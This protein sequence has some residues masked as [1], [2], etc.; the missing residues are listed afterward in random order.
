M[1]GKKK[2]SKKSIIGIIVSSVIGIAG[3]V[4]AIVT[5]CKR[6]KKNK[7]KDHPTKYKPL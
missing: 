3:I 1:S 5:G 6:K 7:L 4:I 2:M